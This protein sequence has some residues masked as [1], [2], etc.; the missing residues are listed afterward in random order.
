MF[1]CLLSGKKGE[2]MCKMILTELSR[3]AESKGERA[4]R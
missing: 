1:S 4:Y 3:S 2:I